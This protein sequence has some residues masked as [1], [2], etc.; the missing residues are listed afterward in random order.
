MAKDVVTFL[1]WAAEP[2]HDER[3]KTGIKAVILFSTLFVLSLYTKRFKWGP[4]KNR[5]IR[6]FTPLLSPRP[7]ILIPWLQSTTL[8]QTR[9]V[10]R[11]RDKSSRVYAT[12]TL[13]FTKMEFSLA[14]FASADLGGSIARLQ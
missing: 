8:P 2:E 5:K 12:R 6:K 14:Y 3:K 11:I 4:I 13:I 1:N 10:I 9:R 7:A